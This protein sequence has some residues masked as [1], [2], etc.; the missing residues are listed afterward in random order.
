MSRASPSIGRR[1]V[2]KL[3]ASMAFEAFILNRLL[4][5]PPSRHQEW[6][7]GL[8]VQGFKS[9]CHSLRTLQH[10]LEMCEGVPP[11][12]KDRIAWETARSSDPARE[13][14]TSPPAESVVL[15]PRAERKDVSFA[16]LRNVIG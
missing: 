5:L 6:L 7:R 12:V 4:R 9:E 2:L 8:L 10:G 13:R 14:T 15:N 11:S 16:A 1:L 3:D